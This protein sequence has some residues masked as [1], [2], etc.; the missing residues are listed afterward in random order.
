MYYLCY[1]H[2]IVICVLCFCLLYMLC[3]CV[4]FIQ[5]VIVICVCTNSMCILCVANKLGTAIGLNI[6]A[7]ICVCAYCLLLFCVLC[8]CVYFLLFLFVLC[9]CAMCMCL[10]YAHIVCTALIFDFHI[11]KTGASVIYYVYQ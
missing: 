4:M 1:V 8:I 2:T 9:Y 10:R 7:F 11:D 6:C 5:Y 3:Y